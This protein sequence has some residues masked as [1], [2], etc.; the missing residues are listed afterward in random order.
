MLTIKWL[1]PE[2]RDLPRRPMPKP[3]RKPLWL[4]AEQYF[5]QER[6]GK[7]PVTLPRLT[8]MEASRG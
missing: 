4:Q 5:R 7:I 3:R 8:F 1:I 6:D 2:V